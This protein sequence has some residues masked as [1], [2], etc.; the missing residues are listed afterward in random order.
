MGSEMCIRD[1][2]WTA[3]QSFSARQR[4]LCCGERFTNAVARPSSL[5]RVVYC[6]RVPRD[7]FGYKM[8][9]TPRLRPML[10]WASVLVSLALR[11]STEQKITLLRA[12]NDRFT[13][14]RTPRTPSHHPRNNEQGNSCRRRTK[15][16]TARLQ[17]KCRP[18]VRG[19]PDAL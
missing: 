3:E 12:H 8:H 15:I 7:C 16:G 2:L 4:F 1:S 10:W 19:S 11:A 6:W 13:N 14:S 5:V 17:Q 18:Y 9:S